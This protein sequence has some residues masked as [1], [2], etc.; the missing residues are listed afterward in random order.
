MLL[1]SSFFSHAS[2]TEYST[3]ITFVC[4]INIAEY[5]TCM[6]FTL[7]IKWGLDSINATFEV[8]F[9]S[10]Y[11]VLWPTCHLSQTNIIAYYV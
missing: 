4:E 9:V 5:G 8:L 7:I 6:I 3:E 2:R 11:L 10:Y 1:N